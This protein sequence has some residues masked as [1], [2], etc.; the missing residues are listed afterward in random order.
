[1]TMRLAAVILGCVVLTAPAFGETAA[2]ETQGKGITMQMVQEM[3]M[4]DFSTVM[5]G[6]QSFSPP[7]NFR[8][9]GTTLIKAMG[10]ESKM[11][12]VGN[13][14]SLKQLIQTPMGPQAI[15]VDLAKIRKAIPQYAAAGDY[16]PSK[17]KKMLDQMPNKTRLPGA[18]MDG[19]AVEGYEF[20]PD[21]ANLPVPSNMQLG[22]AKPAKIRAWINPDDN[23]L[24]KMEIE[25]AQGKVFLK[26]VFSD[27]KTGITFPLG[28]FDLKFPEGVAPMDMTAMVLQQLGT[29]AQPP[30]PAPVA[31]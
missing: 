21:G 22:L 7:D 3:T 13:S 20:I 14:N 30:Q 31:R 11:T 1:M 6:K 26:M 25:D 27:V 15:T 29:A 2:P 18:T 8:L 10:M 24:R 19:V 12:T 5:K 9:E 16:D 4:G 28:T 23:I 17:Y